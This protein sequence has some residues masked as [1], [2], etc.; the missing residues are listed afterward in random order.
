MNNF[1]L[2]S[3]CN[4]SE[5][6]IISLTGCFPGAENPDKFWNNLQNG[7]ES[8]S[9]FSNEEVAE[10]VKDETLL[11]DPNFVKAKAILKDVESFDASFF[12]FNPR[13]AEI[14]DPQHR[15]LLECAWEAL[16]SAGYDSETYKGLIGVYA[17]TSLNNYFF[18]LYSNPS[19]LNSVDGFQLLIGSDKDFLT[20]RIS[21]KLNLEGPSYTVQTACST[22]LVAVHLA[23]QSLLNGECD[24]ALAG[25]VSISASRKS[26]YLYKEGGIQSPDGHCRAFDAKAQGT[27]GGE[28]VGLVVLKRLEDALADR[29]FIHAVIKGSAI[30]NDG[31]FKVSYTAPRIDSQAKVIRT[32]QVVAEVEPET[33]T[34]IEAHGTGTAL[35]DPIEIAA[36]TQAFRT[37]THKKGFCAVGSVKTN[38]GHLDVAAGVTGLIKTVLALKH[39]QIPPSLHFKE[40]NPNID[41]ANSPFYINSVLS[42]WKANGTPRRAGV[43]SFGIGGTNAHVILEEAPTVEPSDP[44]RSWQLLLLSTKTSTALETATAN[45]AEYLKQHPDLNLADVAYTL[46]VG[47]RAFSHRRTV[48]CR[49]IEDAL[50]ALEDPKRVLTSIQETSTRPVAFMFTGLGTHYINMGWELYQVEPTFREEVN[51]CCELLKPLLGLDLKEVL[52]PNQNQASEGA[53]VLNSASITPPSGLNLRQMLGRDRKKPDEASQKLNQTYLTQPSIFVIEYALA[54]LWI[55]W[56]VRPAAMIGYSIGEYVAATLAGVMSLQDALTLVAKR[57]RMIHE[58][59][60]GAMLAVPLSE[61]EGRP[62]LNENLSLSAING[63]SVCAIAGAIDAVDE[64]EHQL[65]EKGL[66]CRRLQTSHAFHSHM[67]EP[68][69]ESFIELVK[70]VSLQPPK[71]PYLSNVTGTWIT[72]EEATDPHYWTQHLC[73]PVRFAD[74]VQQLWSKLNPILLE[75]GPGQTLGSLALQCLESVPIADKVVLPSLRYSYDRQSDI[76]FLLNTLGQLWLCGVHSDWSG[77]YANERRH[78]I[79]LPTY[80]FERQRYWI[81]PQQSSGRYFLPMPTAP[82]LWKSL[83]EAGQFQAVEGISEFDEKTY[84]QVRQSLERLCTAYINLTFRRLGAFSNRSEKYS[85]EQLFKLFDQCKIIPSYRQLLERWLEVLVEQEQLQQD[86]GFFTNLM[87]LSTDSVKTLAE[88]V[89]VK[90]SYTSKLTDYIQRYGEN[91]IAIL[92]GEKE[93][94]EFRFADFFYEEEAEVS[95][96]GTSSRDY[97]KAI[98][99]AILEQLVKS[100]PAEVNLKILEIG[101]GTGMATAELLPV[102]PSK[103][104]NYTFTDVGPLFLEAAKKKFS[105]Y[106]FVEYRLLDIEQS[107]QEQGYSTQSFDVVIAYN[108][109]HVSRKIGEALDHARSLLAPGGFLLLWEY[110][111]PRMDADLIDGLLMNPI[112]DEEMGRNMGNPFLSKEQWQKALKSNGF[113]EV[114]A[115]SETDAFGEHVILAQ[116]SS[117]AALSAPTAFTTLLDQQDADKTIPVSWDKKPD[118]ANWFYIPSWK[119]SMPPQSVTSRSPAESWLVFVDECGLGTQ[120][121]KRLKLEGQNVIPVRVGKQFAHESESSTDGLGQ[122]V[123]TINPRNRNDYDAL[124]TELRAQNLIPKTIAHLWSVT[125]NGHTESTIES[126]EKS[127]TLG[128]YS[129]LFLAQAI[130]QQNL[131][132]SLHIGIVSNNMQELTGDEALSPEKALV[133]GP[134]KV[135]PQEYSNITCRSIDVVLPLPESWQEE[136]LV[137]Q[138]LAELST[139]P[140]DQIIAYRGNYRWVQTCE[141]VRLDGVAEEK[142]RLR[143]GGVYLISG[144]LGGVGLTLAEY[145]ARTVQAKLILI[146][147]SAFP[148]R[149]EWSQWLSTHDEY[150]SISCKIRK[151]QALEALGTQV[152]VLSADVANFEQMSAAIAQA[153]HQFGQINGVIHAAVVQEG[154]VIQLNTPDSAAAA[155]A[156][157]VRGTLILDI[158]F[159]DAQLDFFVLC[160][161]ISTFRPVPGMVNY[162]AENA[163]L[164]TFAH[165]S[166]SKHGRFTRSINWDRWNSV[167]TAVS[168]EARYKALTGKDLRAGMMPEE[169]IEAFRRILS[170]SAVPQIVV[171]TQDLLALTEVEQ[172]P[173]LT[174][175][176]KALASKSRHQRPELKNVYVAPS[177]DIER[178]LADM[179]QNLLG[180]EQVGIHDN[181][182]ALGGDSLSGTVL[183]SQIR[184]EYQIQ[185]PLRSLMEAPSIAELVLA[186]ESI[187]I[188][189][190]EGLTEEEVNLTLDND[191]NSVH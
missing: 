153:N 168:V 145:L 66:A 29:D 37:S 182:F 130:A 160:S 35:G 78:R 147:R 189:Q 7:V 156:P 68:M 120:I 96:P 140:S 76:A 179:F 27:P 56:G 63:P 61:E 6:A 9:F 161:S 131:T 115:F 142:P 82:E 181:F 129:L 47:R 86:E 180:F 4:G 26:G 105:A 135:I 30:N 46:Q 20:T 80:P 148:D 73:Q 50:A 163:F 138:L 34:Y 99:R 14:T 48:V 125:S 175:L 91:M 18:N 72:A 157:K 11:H 49:D 117:S 88:E 158:V 155:L 64:L 106:P 173:F 102:L 43:S 118:I 178:K 143:E 166:V 133:L 113:V 139:Q 171:S 150:D 12:G 144:G 100:L 69:A 165:Y 169:G 84:R 70:T 112:E 184:K 174:A 152:L 39:K 85:L 31:S 183:I 17:G 87:P 74:G 123:Y 10:F 25:G 36:L 2:Y 5:I 83:V 92:T 188:E 95:S 114:A 13:E 137:D 132:D 187:F 119:R 16:E 19:I 146:G 104:T 71:I 77:F 186:I 108:V 172:K 151:V 8:I 58:L 121:V 59:P 176:E 67:M 116:A 33:I 109:L 42:E 141:P 45:L 170:S 52:Y 81:E 60:S 51:R 1:E 28:G 162:I 62:L 97:Y 24:M 57:A 159:K 101:A 94:L 190:L 54:Q 93:P 107:P 177:N 15:L 21:Y 53:Q 98:M 149:N 167:G 75:V 38:I 65:S 128:F 3:P 136:K 103:Q 185:I 23:C 90:W 127:E 122:R 41:F 79:P 134:C 111:Q 191:E 44:S 154:S 55:S 124:F 126:L 40:P 89:K 164:D 22:S 32:A 110:T